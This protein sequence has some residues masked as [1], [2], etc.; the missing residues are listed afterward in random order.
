MDYIIIEVPDM[1][2][3]VSRI[4]LN[5]KQYL[6][7]FTYNDTG[8]YWSFGLS[9]ALGEPIVMG[10]KV[11]PRFPLNVFYYG[12]AELPMGVFGVMTELDKVGRADFREGRA[13]FIFAPVQ[14]FLPWIFRGT[15][16]GRSKRR[17]TRHPPQIHPSS[18]KS[19]VV[20][21]KGIS[22]IEGE[23]DRPKPE[24][25]AHPPFF[26]V[27]RTLLI[28]VPRLVRTTVRRTSGGNPLV[29]K[30]N[31]TIT[32]YIERKLLKESRAKEATALQN[33]DRQYRL[34]AG[35]AGQV[36]FE[37]GEGPTPLHVSF[38]FQKADLKSQNTGKVSIWN[39]NPQHLAE[40]SKDDC[41]VSLK[42]GYGS[43]MP[44][45]FT[46]VVTYT[47]T[48]LD[49]AD[50]CTQL[51]LVDNRI[52]VRDTYASVS[53]SG[54][55]NTKT[56]IQDAADQMGVAVTFSY[57][58]EFVD[59]PNGF[60][61]VGP[62]KDVLTKACDCSS[63]QWSIQNGVLQVKKPGDV[64]SKEVYVLSP[65]T[66]LLGIPKQIQVS[67]DKD[68]SKAQHGWDVEYLMNAAINIDDYVK[69]ESKMV[70]GFFRVYSLEIEG[71][72]VEGSWTCTARLLEVSG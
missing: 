64:M 26:S 63:L 47:S 50:R 29:T 31:L 57:N 33:F 25:L 69:L 8:G 41:V 72:N 53:Y 18:R 21:E 46:G 51:E 28:F 7:R 56:L 10:V 52:E 17:P 6:M 43:V 68:T 11:V 20:G 42:A 61:F 48:S 27:F 30:P 5:G 36:G 58:A 40:L 15:S 12:V 66:G 60:S 71:D 9:D 3:S 16:C 22:A 70:T 1:N 37:I 19:V 23:R 32:L 14:S 67:D 35:Q 65:D 4:V 13:S 45:I 44:L 62:A 2:D 39:L 38:S 59:L 54:T 24:N 55:V 49:G 34:I